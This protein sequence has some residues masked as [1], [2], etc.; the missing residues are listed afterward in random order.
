MVKLGQVPRSLRTRQNLIILLR[1]STAGINHTADWQ[2]YEP[3]EE[4]LVIIAQTR[5]KQG[6]RQKLSKL[7]MSR[8]FA[9]IG[10]SRL[11]VLNPA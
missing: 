10:M 9:D 7:A 4:I 1:F 8:T 11:I 5:L 2:E 6:N 3:K